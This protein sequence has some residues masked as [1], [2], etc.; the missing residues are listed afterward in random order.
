MVDTQCKCLSLWVSVVTPR[1]S[2]GTQNRQKSA[3]GAMMSLQTSANIFVIS[4]HLFAMCF[5]FKRE[6][7][8]LFWLPVIVL[9]SHRN[10]KFSLDYG[11][12]IWE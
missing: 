7:L 9:N 12:I 2:G 8:E 6:R 4:L 5:T 1:D 11:Y 3:N 10:S